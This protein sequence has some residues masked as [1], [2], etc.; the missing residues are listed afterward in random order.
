MPP[1]SLLIKP[2]SSNC[3]LHCKYCFYNSVAQNRMTESYGIMSRETLEILVKKALAYAEDYCIFAF[4]GGEPTV[5]GIDFYRS[6]INFVKLYNYKH[7]KIDYSIQTNGLLINEE[8]ARLFKENNFLVGISLDGP[9]DI[10]DMMRV[11]I[12]GKG[13]FTRVIRTIELFNKFKVDYNILCVVN[14]IVA[15]HINQVYTFFKKNNFQYLQFIPCLDPLGEEPEGY[16]FS[17]TAER[18]TYFLKNLFD[19]W[20][21]DIINGKLISIRYFD[22]LVGLA[23]GKPPESCGMTGV[24]TP[25]FVIESNGGV[26]PC[27]FYVIDEWFMGNI[28]DQSFEGLYNCKSVTQFAEVSRYVDPECKECYWYGLCRGG[29]R[30]D[31]EP[32]ADSR[33]V[34]N[35][36]CASYK[37]FFEYATERIIKLARMLQKR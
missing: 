22:N 32:F 5:T 7:L 21:E 4:Q 15:R 30:R 12:N 8:W 16:E 35:R 17:L 19:L 25:Y 24:C 9:K 2:A 10:H 6:L 34:L 27:D 23:M 11:D 37:E 3:N 1:I 31:R 26:Y 33:P 28:H 36:F 13:S 29:C 20:Y 14:N 18:Y